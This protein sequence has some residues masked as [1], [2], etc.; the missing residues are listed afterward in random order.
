MLKAIDSKDA[1]KSVELIQEF[2]E[3]MRNVDQGAEYVAWVTEPVNLKRM[4]SS[5]IDNLGVP[6][7]AMAIRRLLMSRTQKAVLLIQAMEIAI[8]RVHNL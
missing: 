7:R 1:K 8:K 6:A 5:I 3:M 2:R 4:Q